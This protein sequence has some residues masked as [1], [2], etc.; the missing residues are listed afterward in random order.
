MCMREKMCTS[1]RSNYPVFLIDVTFHA[2]L[3]CARVRNYGEF[4]AHA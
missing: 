1:L 4:L 2:R 3:D